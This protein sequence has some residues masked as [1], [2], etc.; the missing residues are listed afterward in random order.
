MLSATTPRIGASRRDFL[1]TASAAAAAAW[2]IPLG[3]R[4]FANVSAN[5]RPRI[6]CIGVGSMGTGDAHDHAHFGDVTAICDVDLRHANRALADKA[7]CNGKAFLTQ[8]YRRVLDRS[9]VDVVSIVTVDHWHVKIAIEALEAGKHVFCQKPLTLTLEEGRLINAAKAKHPELAFLVGT[10]QRTAQ[11]LFLRAVNMVHQGMLG[12]I[13]KVTIGLDGCPTGGPFPV[14][15]VPKDLDW[16][17]WQGPAPAH[18]F[19]ERRC[20]YE[21]RWWY[22]YS[23]GKFTDWGAHH[24]DIALWAL[25]RNSPDTPYDK[26]LVRIDGRDAKHPVEIRDGYAAVDDSY[27]TSHDF[28]VVCHFADGLE[29]TVTSR[30]DNGILFDGEHGRMF[31]NRE[32]ITGKPVEEDW[33]AG[34]FGAQELRALFKGKPA[35]GH[36][37]NFYR[38]IREGGET[39]SDVASHVAAMDV[40]HLTAIAARLGREIAWD[41]ST[42][43]IPGDSQ[44]AALLS[45]TPRK[46][47][48]FLKV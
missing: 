22:E 2:T 34:R 24:V 31:V 11:N 8:D 5:D 44:A 21:F 18:A 45:R 29:M 27:N 46:G 16:E 28:A 17:M 43:T 19:R 15:E 6:G 20:H 23:A 48:E 47:Y 3:E 14:A 25:Q 12:R 1:R 41:A 40:C 4:A 39:I 35:E 7:I 13:N 33:D 9:D 42:Q 36:K 38:A 26:R 30:G 10:Q 37:D 32:R